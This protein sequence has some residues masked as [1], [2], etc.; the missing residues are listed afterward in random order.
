MVGVQVGQ[1]GQVDGLIPVGRT[2]KTD[3]PL[4]VAVG[5]GKGAIGVLI[6]LI[7]TSPIA[8]KSEAMMLKPWLMTAPMLLCTGLGMLPARP[9]T[10]VAV[11]SSSMKSPG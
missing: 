5:R 11:T 8:S 9:G 1:V 7:V 4:T 2:G 3:L 6:G 10:V